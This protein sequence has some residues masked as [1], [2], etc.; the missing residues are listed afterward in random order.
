MN[1]V[2]PK[3]AFSPER[4]QGVERGSRREPQTTTTAREAFHNFEFLTMVFSFAL[5]TFS[6][7]VPS[8]PKGSTNFDKLC[9]T[10]PISEMLKMNASTVLTKGYENKHPRSRAENKPNQTQFH[11]QS[12]RT[13]HQLPIDKPASILIIPPCHSYCRL[14]LSIGSHYVKSSYI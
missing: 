7:F 9:K 10:N 6:S 12:K 2:Y 1:L 8:C 5:C 3:P 11:A 13:N 14:V 4:P